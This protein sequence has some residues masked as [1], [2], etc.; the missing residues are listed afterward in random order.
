VKK[1]LS[2]QSHVVYGYVGNK[3]AVYPLQYMGF[4]VC[5]IYT[6][7]FSNHTGY[8][9]W[10]G[11][12]LN[13]ESILKI[14]EQLIQLGV[15]NDCVAVLSG[16]MGNGDICK[17]VQKAVKLLKDHYPH[18]TYL[19]DPVMGN[20]HCFVKPDVVDF[21]KHHLTA[22]IITPNHYEAELLSGIKINDKHS[23]RE[24]AQ[25]FHD[26]KNIKIVVITGV[27]FDNDS[28]LMTFCS[29][30]KNDYFVENSFIHFDYPVNG[31]GDLFSSLFLG[32]YLKNYSFSDILK[33]S[34]H[35]LEAV[36]KNT[37]ASL[38]KELQVLSV[39]YD[40]E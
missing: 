32:F 11:D 3:A 14:V 26:K 20:Q 40:D 34:T 25:F 33:K 9:T 2:I 35:Y 36:L 6:V 37:Y 5:P 16:Y 24:I 22:D 29:D 27:K 30:G 17:S 39:R 12:A 18:I 13:H 7:Q 38:Q 4:D 31:T 19:C 28:H 10:A 23:L 15:M 21:F 1:I 8:G